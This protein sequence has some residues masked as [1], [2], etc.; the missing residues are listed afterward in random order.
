[1][2]TDKVYIEHIIEA[3]DAIRDYSKDLTRDTLKDAEHRMAKDAIVR[4]LEIIGEASKNLS[5]EFK[6][7]E[8]GTPWRAVVAMRNNL[9][10]EYF[11]IDLEDVWDTVQNDLPKLKIS[12]KKYLVN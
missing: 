4:E 8:E 11:G 10:H 6:E 2:D 1:M 7:K 9:I 12:L 3:I 5:D